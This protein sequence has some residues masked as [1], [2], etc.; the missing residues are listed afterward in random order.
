[1][2]MF[3]LLRESGTRLPK[4]IGSTISIV[5]ALIIGEAAVNAGIVSAPTVIIV[6][7]TAVCSFI[8]PNLLTIGV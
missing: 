7:L 1:M 4:S 3:V 8:L 5:G 6:A 2:V